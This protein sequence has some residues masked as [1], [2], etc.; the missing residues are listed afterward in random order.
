MIS[1]LDE[2]FH[3]KKETQ[4]METPTV[5]SVAVAAPAPVQQQLVVHPM[6]LPT[7]P[8]W[9]QLSMWLQVILAVLPAAIAPVVSA[10]TLGIITTETQ[11]AGGVLA[12]VQQQQAAQDQT[13]Q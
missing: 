12:G 3:H 10:K 11:L 7:H 1:I 2:L 4:K 8:V 6:A 5:T 9:S 13:A